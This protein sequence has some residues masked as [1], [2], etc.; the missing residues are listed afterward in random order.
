MFTFKLLT[1]VNTK[2][3]IKEPTLHD[4]FYFLASEN[5]HKDIVELLIKNNA[6]VN[7]ADKDGRTALHWGL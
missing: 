3:L 6:D 4:S 1:S 2:I 7:L 5:G